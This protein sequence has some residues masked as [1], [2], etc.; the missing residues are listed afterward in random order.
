MPVAA[1]VA[2]LHPDDAARVRAIIG[3][4]AVSNASL[5]VDYRVVW[6]S[7]EVRFVL[8]AGRSQTNAQ[9]RQTSIVGI[10]R[11]VIS[12]HA[13]QEAVRESRERLQLAL[14]ASASGVWVWEV[15]SN[16]LEWDAQAQV[17]FGH[18]FVAGPVSF[19]VLGSRRAPR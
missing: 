8:A 2:R 6:P 4:T 16:R 19:S 13:A 14:N 12:E 7:G 11:D 5:A 18:H 15:A 1:L 17:I 9:G 3:A 10:L